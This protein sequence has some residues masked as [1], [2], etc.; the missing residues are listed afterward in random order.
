VAIVGN[1]EIRFNHME[2]T[3]PMGTLTPEFTDDVAG[4]YGDVYGFTCT[5][6]KMFGQRSITMRAGHNDF[7]LLIE[8]DQP[9]V[10]PGFDHLG[11]EL[12]SRAEVDATLAKVKQWQEKDARVEL[13]EYDDGVMD[14]RLYRAY[15]V[16]HL[17]PIWFD[18]QFSEPVG[19]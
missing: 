7:I 2:I 9:M 10:A 18:V 5:S 3:F 14:D 8:G 16:R 19:P 12:E 1:V 13:K 6:Q 17:L 15:Y 4:F 11:F